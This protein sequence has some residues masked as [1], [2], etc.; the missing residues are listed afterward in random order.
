MKVLLVQPPVEDFYY[1]RIRTYPLGLL[2]LAT[3]LKDICEVK[4]FDFTQK[5]KPRRVESPF[6]ELK[7]YYREGIETPFSLF[8]RYSRYGY[9]DGEIER[10]IVEENPDIICISSL[11][12]AYSSFAASVAKIAK[13]VKSDAITIF[14]GH[15]ATSLA[16]LLLKEEFV[17]YVIRGEG[18][19]PLFELIGLLQGRKSKDLKDIEGLCFKT[20]SGIYLSERLNYEKEIDSVP[21]R[22]LIRRDDYKIGNKAYTFFL[23]S[24]GCPNSCAFCSKMALPYRERSLESIEAELDSLKRDGVEWID[25]EDDMLIS[26]EERFLKILE[27]FKNRGFF[28]S[29]MNGIYF[30][31][32]TEKIVKKMEEVGFKRLNLSLVDLSPSVLLG[33]RRR[34]TGDWEKI[35]RILESSGLNLEVH[36]IVGLPNQTV[37]DVLKTI[38]FLAQR[39]C[40]LGPSIYYLFPKSNETRRVL[41]DKWYEK[42]HYMRSSV[43]LPINP[44]FSRDALFTLLKI[45]RFV[46]FLKGFVDRCKENITLKDIEL[47][48]PEDNEIF[49]WFINKKSF[50]AFD[51]KVHRFFEEPQNKEIIEEFFRLMEGQK[52]KGFKTSYYVEFK[53][54]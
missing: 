9:T 6:P 3:K 52:I 11:F 23:T 18:E 41:G 28:L 19:T 14:G 37:F 27:L 33:Q 34:L 40:L 48:T 8:R 36:F 22:K 25:F 26:G 1:T 32:I 17:D 38:S 15:H 7:E 5:R 49:K 30:G 20:K 4:I 43:L 50:L 51:E 44:F 21:E 35:F 31:S 54:E 24:R 12:S 39:R 45:C 16:G 53:T 29:A 13:R 46:N 47:P 2:Y 42:L 10:V